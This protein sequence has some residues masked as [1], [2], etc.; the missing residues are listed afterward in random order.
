[1]VQKKKNTNGLNENEN[2]QATSYQ[3]A[4]SDEVFR[5]IGKTW[6]HMDQINKTDINEISISYVNE[7]NQLNFSMSCIDLDH[8]IFV[9]QDLLYWQYV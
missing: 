8:G 6:K 3:C 9:T 2:T 5:A 1:M 4:M 7:K